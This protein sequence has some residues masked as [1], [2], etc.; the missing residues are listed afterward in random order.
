MTG[1]LD[2]F[3]HKRRRPQQREEGIQVLCVLRQIREGLEEEKAKFSP[4]GNP[5]ILAQT[6]EG[7]SGAEKGNRPQL[8]QAWWA[9]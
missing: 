2:Y 6:V 8:P 7:L 9:A 5:A 1:K 4:K 3:L